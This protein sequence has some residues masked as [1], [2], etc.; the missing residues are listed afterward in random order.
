MFETMPNEKRLYRS[1]EFVSEEK[2]RITRLISVTTA[3]GLLLTRAVVCLY[4]APQV[5]I[6]AMDAHELAL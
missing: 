2:S 3:T 1:N 5:I 4:A 6:A